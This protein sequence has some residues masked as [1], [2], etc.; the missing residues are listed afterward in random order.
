MIR[1]LAHLFPILSR[2]KDVSLSQCGGRQSILLTVGG[3]WGGRGAKSY[4]HRKSLALSINHSIL[5]DYN[6]RIVYAHKYSHS[7][8]VSAE[9]IF[10]SLPQR[11]HITVVSS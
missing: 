8:V 3:G 6:Y 1:L 9:L 11:L 5:S 10:A 2:Q 4:D 7:S